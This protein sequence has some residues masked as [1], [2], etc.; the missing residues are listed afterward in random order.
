MQILL[1]KRALNSAP[2]RSE[3]VHARHQMMLTHNGKSD[4]KTQEEM[5]AINSTP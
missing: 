4:L 2:E 5:Y 1:H 3:P